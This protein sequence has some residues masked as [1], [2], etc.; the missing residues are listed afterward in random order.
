MSSG[1]R[2]A[3]CG[4]GGTD[5]SATRLN[6]AEADESVEVKWEERTAPQNAYDPERLETVVPK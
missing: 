6:G 1:L 3:D 4:E 2:G 5:G